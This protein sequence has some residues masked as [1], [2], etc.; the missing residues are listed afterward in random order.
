MAGYIYLVHAAKHVTTN[1]PIYKIGKSK[2][3][4][5]SRLSAYGK[6]KERRVLCWIRVANH[7]AVEN[8]II[9]EFS[10][11]FVLRDGREWFEGNS[12]VM[13]DIINTI[14]N[15]SRHPELLPT[16][17][18]LGRCWKECDLCNCHFSEGD[19][20]DV[21]ENMTIDYGMCRGLC[22]H[23]VN[24]TWNH[25]QK[26]I[27]MHSYYQPIKCE[28]PE[29]VLTKCPNCDDMHPN[30]HYLAH[31]GICDDCQSG[32]QIHKS[33]LQAEKR[34]MYYQQISESGIPGIIS[35]YCYLNDNDNCELGWCRV[36][37]AVYDTLFEIYT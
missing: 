36:L 5:Q 10:K 23:S 16:D 12:S 13:L 29:C 11:K 33:I 28:K 32:V 25:K 7:H 19:F 17:H 2:V 30:W 6:K 24:C 3:D 22:D 1:T 26:P 15:L 35:D 37:D 34:E 8:R 9:D 21:K 27:P 14:T 31:D 20:D 18:D 4:D